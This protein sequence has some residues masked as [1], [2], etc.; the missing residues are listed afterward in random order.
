MEFVQSIIALLASLALALAGVLFPALVPQKSPSATLPA[1]PTHV[2]TVAP[3]PVAPSTPQR[4]ATTTASI[5]KPAP[6]GVTPAQPTK[7]AP[8]PLPTSPSKSEAEVN[9]DTR[10]A[11]VNILC[12]TKYGGYLQ[13]ISGSGVMVDSRGIVLTNAH[14]GQYFLLR[15][16]GVQDNIDCVIRTGSPAQPRYR[17]TLLYLPPAWIADNASQL[18][19]AQAQGT[20]KND[21]ALLL[22]TGTTDPSGTLPAS[23][24][25]VA[26]DLSYPSLGEQMLL[27]AYPAGFLSGEII[28][29]ALYASSALAYA[30]QLYSFDD[31]LTKVDLFSIGGTI[32]SQAGSSGGAVVRRSDGKLL[33][34]IATATIADSTSQRDLRAITIS[35]IN[36]S[37]KAGGKVGLAELLSGDVSAKATTFNTDVAPGLTKQLEKVLNGN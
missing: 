4:A 25:H 24:A 29:K 13:P 17:A 6:V 7:P 26:M 20:G 3:E 32:L 5:V 37:L 27:A 23:F 28:T 1:D 21:Y 15:N 36:A 14:V 33:G 31:D 35:H 2:T 11:L 8:A 12:T 30:T 16:Y 18:V 9:T 22:I 10:A 19:A 34:V